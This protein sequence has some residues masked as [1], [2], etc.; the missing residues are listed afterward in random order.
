MRNG[1]RHAWA[2]CRPQHILSPMMTYLPRRGHQKSPPTSQTTCSPYPFGNRED[3]KRTDETPEKQ[4]EQ[5]RPALA[6]HSPGSCQGGS[7][8]TSSGKPS[9]PPLP[10][11]L[12]RARGPRLHGPPRERAFGTWSRSRH[13]RG[14]P[15][16]SAAKH[17]WGCGSHALVQPGVFFPVCAR[18][19][20]RL[21]SVSG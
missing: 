4:P 14:S 19:L 10:S 1:A 7:P 11:F 17:P 13:R 9:E 12:P 15:S 16:P 5:G 6:T 8:R 2:P 21:W 20:S 18:S 3:K